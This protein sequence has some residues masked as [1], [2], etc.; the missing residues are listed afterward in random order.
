MERVGTK[1]PTELIVGYCRKGWGHIREKRGKTSSTFEEAS[2]IFVFKTDENQKKKQIKIHCCTWALCATVHKEKVYVFRLKLTH[3]ALVITYIWTIR[4]FDYTVCSV[5]LERD[6]KR[7]FLKMERQFRSDQT[8][9][10]KR[11][12][13]GGGLLRPENFHLSRTVPFTFGP[14]FPEI[15]A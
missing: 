8:D 6:W 7:K 14:K 1:T 15:L 9:R 11:T 3:T 5:Q 2:N 4:H 10:S 12:T 13:S